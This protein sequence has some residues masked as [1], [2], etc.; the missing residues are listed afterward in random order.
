MSALDALFE[1][2]PERL[3]AEQLTRVLGLSST[4]VTYRL[5]RDGEVPAIRLRGHWVILRD[6]VKEHMRGK[7]NV[8]PPSAAPM[9]KE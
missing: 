6:D 8:E 9:E 1:G 7:Y 4:N 3:S 2:L 5:L